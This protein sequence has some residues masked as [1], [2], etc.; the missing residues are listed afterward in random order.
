MNETDIGHLRR[1]FMLSTAARASGNRPYGA[2]LVGKNGAVLS[3]GRN[4]VHTK[5]D[6]TAHAESAALRDAGAQHG[7]DSLQD[8][9]MY[10]SGE[11]CA[12]CSAAMALAGIARVVFGLSAPRAR[13]LL[14]APTT[15]VSLRCAD[16]MSQ[17]SYPVEVVGPVLESEAEAAFG[18]L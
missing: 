16:V 18:S 13:Q 14:P 9:T 11:P 15:G 1:A 6:V 5:H 17:A 2:V 10:A 4:E 12:M 8:A 3:E 7:L